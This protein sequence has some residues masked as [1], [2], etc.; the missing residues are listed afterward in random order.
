MQWHSA[1]TC[2]AHCSPVEMGTFESREEEIPGAASAMTNLR[3]EQSQKTLVLPVAGTQ[4]LRHVP[5]PSQ[6]DLT[7]KVGEPSECHLI[8]VI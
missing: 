3:Y 6:R 5:A 4:S 8:R 1:R 2:E 7:L